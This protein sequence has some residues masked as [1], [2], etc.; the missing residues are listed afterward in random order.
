M[1]KALLASSLAQSNESVAIGPVV[2]ELVSKELYVR[3]IA[4]VR[5]TALGRFPGVWRVGLAVGTSWSH[6]RTA[7]LHCLDL[8][9]RI[10]RR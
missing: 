10:R 5:S 7:N 2:N 4:Y 3:K 8:P 1:E 9:G 6:R